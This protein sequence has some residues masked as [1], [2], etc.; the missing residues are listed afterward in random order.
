MIERKK[1]RPGLRLAC[2][3]LIIIL[4]GAVLLSLPVSHGEG[5]TL[6]FLDALFLSTSAVCVTGLT[7]V[8][9]SVTLSRTG[10]VILMV[11]IQL[12]GL[13]YALVAVLFILLTSGRLNLIS[14]NLIKDSFGA[15]N[16]TDLKKLLIIAISSTALLEAIGA[17][18]LAAAFSSRY[19]L[20]ESLYLGLFHS[21]SAF[22]NAGF[23]LFSTSLMSWSDN[24]AVVITIAML[25]ILG[26]LGFVLYSD[27]LRNFRRKVL[28]IHTKI[29][30]STTLFLIVAGTLL[31]RLAIED[32]SW[33]DAFFQSVTTR[34]AGFFS[35]D[36]SALPV[37]AYFL[38]IV[39]MFIGAS[40]GST[41]GG[42]KTTSA[43]TAAAASF[44]FILGRRFVVFRRAI[45]N[46]SIMKAFF[47]MI[48][49]VLFIFLTVLL[50]AFAEPDIPFDM[51]LYE[52]ISAFATVG[53]TMGITPSL[54][55]AA[56][57]IL[58]AAM[59]IGRVGILTILGSFASTPSGQVKYLEEK[60]IIG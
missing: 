9:I 22:N 23:D 51:L 52:A 1:P 46:E 53:L 13:G 17:A 48:I 57:L 6:G 3:F 16:R 14:G 44:S 28:S 12:G 19:P 43:F 40:P 21:V 45:S 60:L 5:E 36:Q 35:I 56:K 11:L 20:G 25:I 34:T 10:S 8:D 58:I 27:I 4:V 42:V 54:G 30:L 18:I 41:G 59:F 37:S 32:A 39:L 55:I 49:S 31:F 50:L 15:D 24:P 2:E 29:V 7:P 26:G 33:L 47:V 38:T